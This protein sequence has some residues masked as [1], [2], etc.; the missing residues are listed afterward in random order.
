MNDG[1]T[2]PRRCDRGGNGNGKRQ[3]T[4]RGRPVD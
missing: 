1:L 3:V 2:L 4:Y